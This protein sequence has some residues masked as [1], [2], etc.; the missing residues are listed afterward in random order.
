MITIMLKATNRF[1]IFINETTP[2]TK[3]SATNNEIVEITITNKYDRQWFLYSKF[4]IY[5]LKL[6][7]LYIQINDKTFSIDI[8]NI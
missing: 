2:S 8:I 4:E 6:N 3:F 5:S 7:S 1:N